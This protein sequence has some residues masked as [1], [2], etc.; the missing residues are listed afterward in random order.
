MC[1]DFFCTESEVKIV[2]SKFMGAAVRAAIVIL[3]V[4]TPSL[5]LPGTTDE[6]A[7]MVTLVGIALAFFVVAEYASRFPALIE[8]RDAPPFNRVRIL[9]LFLTLFCLSIVIAGGNLGGSTLV[10][11]LSALGLLV[12]RALEFPLS[13][14]NVVLEHLPSG[15][16]VVSE[17]QVTIMAGLSVF[18]MLFGMLV[19]ASLLRLQRWPYRGTAFNVWINLP[20]FDPTTGG[21]VVT[22]LMRDSRVNIILAFTLPFVIPIVGGLAAEHVGLAV[23]ASPHAMVWG[24]ALWTFLPLSMFMRGLAMARI[25]DLIMERRARLTDTTDADM[26]SPNPAY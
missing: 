23:L 1:A 14:L 18:I 26:P 5:L 13:P 15:V 2:L 12:G 20:T 10:L 21:D 22:R 4:A 25:A 7:Q 16:G 3:V 9:T 6:G 8:F 11:I 24:I 19:F 17:I